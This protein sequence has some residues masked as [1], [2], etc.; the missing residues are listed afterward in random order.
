MINEI[1]GIYDLAAECY[2]QFI[3]C[4]NAAVAKMTFEKLYKDKRLNVPMLYDY[5][6]LYE[7][8]KLATFDDNSGRFENVEM[9][10]LFI[11]F[12]S[13]DENLKVPQ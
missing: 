13:I 1:Y 9:Q 8:R 3:P 11:N 10:D 4:Q 7:V 12:G 2:V 6:N 5:P